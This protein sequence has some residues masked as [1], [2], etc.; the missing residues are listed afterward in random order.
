MSFHFNGHHAV[1]YGDA[2][3]DA[4]RLSGPVNGDKTAG[5]GF[6]ASQIYAFQLVALICSSIS[7]V[8][9]VITFYWFLTMRRRFRHQ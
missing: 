5:A 2:E 8:M 1:G 6:S 7:L 3:N 9:T 4:T